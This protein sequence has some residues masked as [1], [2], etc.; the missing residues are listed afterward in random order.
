MIG[1]NDLTKA[2]LYA[3]NLPWN[4]FTPQ[5]LGPCVMSFIE[6]YEPFFRRW[7]EIYF[8]NFQYLYGNH[9]IKWSKRYGF[10]VDYDFLRRDT[11]YSMRAMTNIART[12][13]EG[14]TSFIFGVLPEWDVASADPQSVKGKRF[15]RIYEALLNAYMERLLMEKEFRAAAFIY[16]LYGQFNCEIDWNALAGQ[17]MDIPRFAKTMKPIYTSTMAPNMF[18][19][20]LIEVPSQIM[21]LDGQPAMEEVWD[22]VLDAA[23]K[24]IIDK[25][26]SGDVAVKMRTPLE[27]SR[28][29]G[30]YGSHR[31]RYWQTY[32]LMDY[33]E[34]MD[35]YGNLPGQTD[36]F[37]RIRP[38]YSNAAVYNM[39]TRFYMRMQFTTPPTVDLGMNRSQNI[40]KGSAFKY[41]VFVVNH[42]DMP[43]PKK[44]PNGR[45]VVVANGQCTHITTPSYSTNKLDGWHPFAEAQWIIAPPSSI[46]MGPVNDVIR[47]NR[48]LDIKDSLIATSVRRNMGPMLLIDKASG[49]D[50]QQ[51]TGEPGR[52]H[53]VNDIN[54]ARWLHDDMP[55]PPVLARLREMDKEDVYDTSGAGDAIRGSSESTATSGYQEKIRE[56]REIKRLIPARRGFESAVET[57]GEKII[58][59]LKANAMTLNDST[60]G[61]LKR[62]AAGEFTT[63]DVVAFMTTPIDFG[64]DVKVVKSSMTVKSEATEQATYMELSKEPAVAQR[65]A[66]DAKV[67]DTFLKKFGA[68]DLRDASAP[69]RDRAEREN[70]VFLDMIRLGPNNLDG[71]AR[72]QIIFEDD[73]D[74]HMAEHDDFYIKNYDEFRNNP[75]LQAIFQDHKEAHR[76]AREVKLGK[77]PPET[78]NFTSQMQQVAMQSAQPT[79]QN[80]YLDTRL[81]RA[82][83]AKQLAAAEQLQENNESS[84]NA[85]SPD[86]NAPLGEKQAPQAPRQPSISPG[87]GGRIDPNAPAQNTPQGRARGEF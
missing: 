19:E 33:D 85:G 39:A 7:A 81:R 1:P 37:R 10:A 27:Y 30:T 49:L 63:Q 86:G 32:D 40:F 84:N 34:F 13:T 61:F 82:A 4:R 75:E 58:A 8:E 48:E 14:L 18:T 38:V 59:C 68:E 72:P 65:L 66:S 47:K 50:P 62:S 52:Y 20:G 35:K 44:W 74:I 76:L 79:L 23:G 3:P 64:I 21:T 53:E 83:E 24:Q 42:W 45:R 77:L 80:I 43:H 15:K 60:M 29:L 67:L 78:A 46:S 57:I 31:T 17:L 54:G 56:E 41:K 16:V 73:D 55:I 26:F 25:V 22:P 71:I 70:E 12:V 5:D 11:P 36:E 51:I 6:D 28:E 87:G 9:S 69:H 2:E